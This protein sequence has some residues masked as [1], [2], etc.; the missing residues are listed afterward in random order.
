MLTEI[1]YLSRPP[2]FLKD[3]QP[4]RKSSGNLPCWPQ[5][6]C[7][8]HMHLNTIVF[9]PYPTVAS[10]QTSSLFVY[11]TDHHERSVFGTVGYSLW[12]RWVD[13]SLVVSVIEEITLPIHT[14]WAQS[15]QLEVGWNHSIYSGGENP[16]THLKGFMYLDLLKVISYFAPRDSSPSTYHLG[17]YVWYFFQASNKQI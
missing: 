3:T 13:K 17:A 12:R 9:W 5:Y 10:L 16:A 1:I 7:I 2:Y 8:K 6:T 4:K 11:R 15:H 14:R